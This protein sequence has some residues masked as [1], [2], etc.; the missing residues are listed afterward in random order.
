MKS[1]TIISSTI[2]LY[3]L[4]TTAAPTV[5]EPLNL[6]R[7]NHKANI[8]ATLAKGAETWMTNP[9]GAMD[10]I[11]R[12]KNAE[13]GAQIIIGKARGPVTGLDRHPQLQASMAEAARN[14][15][16]LAKGAE[17][18]MTNPAGAMDRIKRK[19]N[20]EKGAQIITGKARGPVTGLD[21]H[22]QLQASMAEAARNQGA[23]VKK[24]SGGSII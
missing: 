20:V 10:R 15:G 1:T 8:G 18:W 13:K 16:A 5:T 6:S 2:L 7:R 4:L 19:K 23:W 17:T 22:P 21:R 24:I 9:A 11:K 3:A 14:Q 12:K